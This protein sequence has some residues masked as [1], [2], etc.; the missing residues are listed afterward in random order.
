MNNL[1]RMHSIVQYDCSRTKATKL[2]VVFFTA[3]SYC[4]HQPF[5]LQNL[6]QHEFRLHS[7]SIGLCPLLI[8]LG[9]LHTVCELHLV[10]S[11]NFMATASF[12]LHIAYK[13]TIQCIKGFVFRH[14]V[15]TQEAH[16]PYTCLGWG[17]GDTVDPTL[18]QGECGLAQGKTTFSFSFS[19]NFFFLQP[20]CLVCNF[21][22]GDP[23]WMRPQLILNVLSSSLIC[24]LYS[25][26]I[27]LSNAMI[28]NKVQLVIKL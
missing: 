17:G 15:S 1:H 11:V 25:K 10:N 8:Y 21:M 18:N 19:T 12:P 9:P 4:Y 14:W 6:Y 2:S 23:L 7:T 3:R 26:I 16:H 5:G 13:E 28:L 27:P 20:T 24:A 22:Y